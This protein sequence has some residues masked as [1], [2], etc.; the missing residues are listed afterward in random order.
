MSAETLSTKWTDASFIQWFIIALIFISLV[1]LF[2]DF[3]SAIVSLGYALGL[4]IG[5]EIV[6]VLTG[7]VTSVIIGF[8]GIFMEVIIHSLRRYR[9]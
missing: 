8:L 6:F 3:I 7:D 5:G 1:E 2:T 9:S 4:I